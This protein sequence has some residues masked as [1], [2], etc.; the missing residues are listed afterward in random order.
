MK[1]KGERETRVKIR[2]CDVGVKLALENEDR[3]RMKSIVR[4]NSYTPRHTKQTHLSAS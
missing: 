1:G 3:R 4:Y 2:D